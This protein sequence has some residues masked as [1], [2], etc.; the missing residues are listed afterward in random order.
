MHRDAAVPCYLHLL[1]CEDAIE[2]VRSSCCKT[3]RYLITSSEWR[4]KLSS[5]VIIPQTVEIRAGW[6]CVY[7]CRMRRACRFSHSFHR[8]TRCCS[9]NRMFLPYLHASRPGWLRTVTPW[10]GLNLR[11]PKMEVCVCWTLPKVQMFCYSRYFLV[12][13]NYFIVE[14]M[15][16]C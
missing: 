4:W 6:S 3:G 1:V 16:D 14:Y 9:I 11:G 13:N 15:I 8:F 12:W 2:S 5:A 10:F 7:P